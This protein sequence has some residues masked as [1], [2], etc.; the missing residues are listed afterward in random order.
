MVHYKHMHIVGHL[1]NDKDIFV[2]V[3]RPV[4]DRYYGLSKEFNTNKE[5]TSNRAKMHK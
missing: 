5:K 1:R 3:M 4:I 2:G